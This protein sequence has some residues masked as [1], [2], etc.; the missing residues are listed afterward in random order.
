M[1]IFSI[2]W[3]YGFSNPL[4]LENNFS[5][6]DLRGIEFTS[7]AGIERDNQFTCFCNLETCALEFLCCGFGYF[8]DVEILGLGQ[9]LRILCRSPGNPPFLLW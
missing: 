2:A 8:C 3:G 1:E 5:P 7:L 4:G 6:L 9:H